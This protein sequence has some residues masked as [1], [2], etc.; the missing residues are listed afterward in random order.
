MSALAIDDTVPAGFKP[1][2][3]TE[4]FAGHNGPLFL[5]RDA[6]GRVTLA[7][8]V[9]G[10]HLNAGG[11]CHGGML[12]TVADMALGITTTVA[13]GGRKFLPTVSMTSDFLRPAE[14]GQWVEAIGEPL[15]VTR[16]LGFADCRVTAD[17]A[18]ILRASGTLKIPQAEWSFDFN[19]I[20]AD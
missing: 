15:R 1:F 2:P 4:G 8:R 16:N 5:K 9:A 6:D 11:V 10:K 17:G 14:L 12:M 18:L 13:A 7:F 20:F 3:I 19:Q